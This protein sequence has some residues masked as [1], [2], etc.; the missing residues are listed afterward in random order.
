M[1]GGL[2]EV[3]STKFFSFNAGPR[4]CLGKKLAMTQMKTVVMEILQNYDIQVVE[5]QK[6]EPAPGPIL[7]M[8]HGL[9]VTLAKRCSS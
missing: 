2:I 8:K 7:R 6:I 4:A 1:T 5:G 3:P 9:R